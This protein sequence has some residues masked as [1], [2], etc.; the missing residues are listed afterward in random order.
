MKITLSL[1]TYHITWRHIIPYHRSLVRHEL[2]A[3]VYK[4]YF[5]NP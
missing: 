2:F 5:F 3:L 1:L 4:G